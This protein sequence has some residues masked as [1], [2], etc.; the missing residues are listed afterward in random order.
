[1]MDKSALHHA[2]MSEEPVKD[3]FSDGWH[4]G[5]YLLSYY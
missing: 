4:K 2:E 3:T 1:M 5:D